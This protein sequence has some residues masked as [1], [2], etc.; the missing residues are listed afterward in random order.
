MENEFNLIETE[1]NADSRKKLVAVIEQYKASMSDILTRSTLW[2]M[3]TC[4]HC[5]R[6][7]NNK[8]I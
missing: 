3:A 6:P 2:K 5:C 8:K 7:F 1:D 4:I